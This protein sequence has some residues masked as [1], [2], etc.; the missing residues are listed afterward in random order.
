MASLALEGAIE[1]STVA[2]PRTQ[3]SPY[4]PASGNGSSS[5]RY[6]VRGV[7]TQLALSRTGAGAEQRGFFLQSRTGFTDGDPTT[8]DGVFVFTGSFT[9]LIGG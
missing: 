1:G 9:T 4:A 3:R 5:S 8:S 7:V 2:N 6:R